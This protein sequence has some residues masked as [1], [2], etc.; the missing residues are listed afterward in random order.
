[1]SFTFD[2]LKTL[3]QDPYLL[4]KASMNG[5]LDIIKKII[6]DILL[7][8]KDEPKLKKLLVLKDEDDG[9]TILHWC[10]TMQQ[11]DIL[12]YISHYYKTCKI[13]IDSLYDNAGWTPFHLIVSSMFDSDVIVNFFLKTFDVDF[14]NL[15]QGTRNK[16]S[17]LH[18]IATKPQKLDL[19]KYFLN[20]NV[21]NCRNL[22]KI[23]DSLGRLPLHLAASNEKCLT[24]VEIMLQYSN[25]M[26]L[27]TR[28]K[29]GYTPLTHALAEGNLDISV[30]LAE[31][32]AEYENDYDDVLKEA[33]NDTFKRDFIKKIKQK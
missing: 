19:I 33:L 21:D 30:L 18:L 5:E 28:D 22:L 8:Q 12:R 27:N 16:T 1:M 14:E 11:E 2:G 32:G 10:I 24:I 26:S 15:T 23:K 7:V 3:E 31:K 20:E 13:N 29:Y 17:V 4:H 9:R 6:D 25:K